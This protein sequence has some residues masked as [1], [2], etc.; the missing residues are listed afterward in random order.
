MPKPI[1]LEDLFK[2]IGENF[3][4]IRNAR[5]EKL[6]VA[7]EAVGV[8]H[9]VLSRIENGRYSG[10]SVEL[11]VKLCNHYQVKLQQILGLEVM[12]VFNLSQS[13]ESGSSSTLKQVVNDVAEGYIQALEQAKS[14]IAFLRSLVTLPEKAPVEVFQL[15]GA[16]ST[17]RSK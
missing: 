3:H 16:K 6:D 10:L 8:S 7:A 2:T 17:K 11:L 13:A 14:E 15:N 9:P 4:T 5:K 1:D 12:Q